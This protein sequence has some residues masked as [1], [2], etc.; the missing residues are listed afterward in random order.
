MIRTVVD[1]A[2][3]ERV[4]DHERVIVFGLGHVARMLGPMLQTLGFRVIACDDG[5]T[6]ALRNRRMAWADRVIE[7]FDAVEVEREVRRVRRR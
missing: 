6:G 2:L 7:S 1:G 3:V 5:D 4:G